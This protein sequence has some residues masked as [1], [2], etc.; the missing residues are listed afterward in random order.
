MLLVVS[1]RLIVQTWR[2]GKFRKSDPDSLLILAFT[3]TAGGGQIDLTHIGVPKHDL[4]GV[5]RGWPQ[6][7]WRP[8]KALLSR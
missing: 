4:R 1:K 2:S 7:Y 3:D 5:Q 8:L 6:H